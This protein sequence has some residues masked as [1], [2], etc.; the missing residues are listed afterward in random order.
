MN[1]QIV[2]D[3]L[4]LTAFTLV[5]GLILGAVYGITKPSIDKANEETKKEAYQAVFADADSF[6]QKDFDFSAF[7]TFFRTLNFSI[8]IF[9]HPFSK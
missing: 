9:I 5:L 6:N 8:Y 4:I 2:H 3:A 7:G 1:K